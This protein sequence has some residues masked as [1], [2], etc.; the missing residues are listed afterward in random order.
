[1]Q[2]FKGKSKGCTYFAAELGDTVDHLPRLLWEGTVDSQGPD[3]PGGKPTVRLV[4]TDLNV[5]C[6]VKGADDSLGHPQWSEAAARGCMG[7]ALK[8]W[9]REVREH[10]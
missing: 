2:L 6:E 5:V 3:V 7:L 9:I 8:A 1:M 4:E 10:E